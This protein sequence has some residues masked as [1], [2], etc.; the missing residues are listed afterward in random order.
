MQTRSDMKI[1][2][3]FDIDSI[4]LSP[5]EEIHLLQVA[6]ESLQN[7]VH[8]SKGKSVVLELFSEDNYVTLRV[9]DDG[10]GISD[11]PE[12]MNHYGLAIMKERSKHL[13]GALKL[14]RQQQGGTC[15]EMQFHPSELAP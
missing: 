12:K 1:T 10:I 5:N 7:A 3:N 14:Y 4:P 9:C 11:D 8:H 13:N 6:K 2:L 15:V